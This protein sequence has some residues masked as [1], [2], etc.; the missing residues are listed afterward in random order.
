MNIYEYLFRIWALGLGIP[1][2]RGPHTKCRP[3]DGDPL[4]HIILPLSVHYTPEACI[5]MQFMWDEKKKK[6]AHMILS[7]T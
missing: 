4:Q 3:L 7:Q 2:I 1:R 5:A 6:S